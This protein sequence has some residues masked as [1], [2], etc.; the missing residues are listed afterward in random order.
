[1]TLHSHIYT[2]RIWKQPSIAREILRNFPTLDPLAILFNSKVY[3][4]KEGDSIAS[5]VSV[6]KFLVTYELGTAYTYEKF[7]GKGYASDMVSHVLEKYDQ[8]FLLCKPNLVSFC[9]ELGFY[10]CS[11]CDMII[12]I[13]RTRY[14][15]F[16][17]PFTRNTI[18]SMKYNKNI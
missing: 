1:M 15:L 6:K 13:R 18:V 5:F 7:R 17:A 8:L 12:N 14:S 10:E 3:F 4:V 9:K 16:L 2:S 11:R